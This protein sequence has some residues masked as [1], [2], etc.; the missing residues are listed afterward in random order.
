[1]LNFYNLIIE[2]TKKKYILNKNINHERLKFSLK[3]NLKLSYTNINIS[4]L[5]CMNCV[6]SKFNEY[7]LM[8][9]KRELSPTYFLICFLL[10]S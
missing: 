9:Y 4:S 10:F 1:M 7:I 8:K 5:T 6:T 3:K 2:L